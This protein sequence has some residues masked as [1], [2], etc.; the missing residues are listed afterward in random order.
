MASYSTIRSDASVNVEN[1][2]FTI[3]DGVDPIAVAEDFDPDVSI[4]DPSLRSPI[5]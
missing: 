2:C 4:I 5:S 1:V 3:S